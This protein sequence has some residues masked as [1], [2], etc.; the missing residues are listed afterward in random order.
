MTSR[1]PL[2]GETEDVSSLTF[3]IILE[4]LEPLF[5]PNVHY[6]LRSGRDRRKSIGEPSRNLLH[7]WQSILA[8]SRCPRSPNCSPRRRWRFPSPAP[9][10]WSAAPECGFVPAYRERF[11][12]PGRKRAEKTTERSLSWIEIRWLGMP[13][14]PATRLYEVPGND[15]SRASK[16]ELGNRQ[17]MPAFFSAK[18]L[19]L[20]RRAT[21]G[22]F[23]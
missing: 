22:K 1:L 9:T 17:A 5:L 13:C 6:L 14:G 12:R 7:G 21:V 8:N 16:T 3:Q 18:G 20:F 4:C 15:R 23:R 2:R 11:A 19:V 10:I